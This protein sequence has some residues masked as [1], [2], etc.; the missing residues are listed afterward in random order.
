MPVKETLK[1]IWQLL[2]NEMKAAVGYQQS[3][4]K[5]LESND[6]SRAISMLENRGRAAMLN[7]SNYHTDTHVIKQRPGRNIYNKKGEFLYTKEL[8]TIAIPYQKFINEVALVFLYGR[9]VLWKNATKNPYQEERERLAKLRNTIGNYDDPAANE[10]QRAEAMQAMQEAKMNLEQLEKRIDEID[11]ETAKSDAAYGKLMEELHQ[12]RFDAHLREAKRYAGAEGCSALLFHTYQQDG[13]A[14]MLI[15]TLAKSKNDDIYTLFDQYDRLVAFAWGYNTR[16]INGK[17]VR[18]YDI[19]TANTIYNCEQN[20]FGKWE[21]NPKPNPIGKIPV[22]VFIQEVEW[23][24]AETMINRVEKAFSINADNID[25]FGSPAIV[26]TGAITNSDDIAAQEEESK[27]F[28]LRDGGDLKYL[29]LDNIGAARKEEIAMLES[30]IMEKTFTPTITLEALRGLSNASGATLRTVMMLANIKADRRKDSHDG[31][32]SR[33]SSLMKSI[34]G[35]VLDVKNKTR[36]DGLVIEHE[37]QEPFGSDV[38]QTFNDLIRQYGAGAISI[39]TVLEQSYLV[40]NAEKELERM[41]KE[42]EEADERKREQMVQ[43]AFA[44][45]E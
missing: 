13:E 39:R 12:A 5:L 27:V 19:Y 30:Q 17:S 35:N 16:D 4:E 14:K 40:P 42:Q 22:I 32:L 25:D 28:E 38:A 15:R 10:E 18:H 45:A 7:L 44:M 3:F 26:A 37:F 11:A 21:S 34:M 1:T 31:L 23:E 20:K 24:G 2:G 29:E 8:N 43:D 9:P 36:Y 33:T 41:K 6:V